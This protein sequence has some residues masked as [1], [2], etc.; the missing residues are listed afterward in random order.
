MFLLLV[1]FS[2]TFAD[3][4]A[5]T[6]QTDREENV[7]DKIWATTT[8][9]QCVVHDQEG[10]RKATGQYLLSNS[11]YPLKKIRPVIVTAI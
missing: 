7:N 1:A 9:V 11:N 2:S 6:A 5:L 3:S 8:H 4:Q 10:Q